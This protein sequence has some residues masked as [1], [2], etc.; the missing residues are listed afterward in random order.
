MPA[1]R[2]GGTT[3]T[4][5]KYDVIALDSTVESEFIG[6]V[7]LA[8]ER[9]SSF[10]ESDELSLVHM[11]PP[12]ERG[13]SHSPINCVGTVGLTVDE[14]RQIDVFVDELESEYEAA[15]IR[16]D[17]RRQ[18]VIAP[19]AHDVLADD[20]TVIFRR[21]NCGGFVIESYREIGIDLLLTDPNNLP[22]VSLE[23]LVRQYP[24]L[25][26][27][28]HN[29][30]VREKYGIPGDGPWSVVLAGYVMNALNRTAEEIRR[31]PH[32]ADVGEA[33][34]PSHRDQPSVESP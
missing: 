16:N 15:R 34:F 13:T 32:T 5:R 3:V 33:F 31:Q 8:G 11:M 20:G 1:I 19:H 14:M 12:L 6:H 30:A 29:P 2:L 7:A 21:F 27:L 25:A 26:T 10:G 4:I 28:L 23:T 17:Q 18:Y 9:K 22:A 24:D